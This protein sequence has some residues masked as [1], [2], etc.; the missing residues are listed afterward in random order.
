[1]QIFNSF[2]VPVRSLKFLPSDC[3]T[4]KEESSDELLSRK[5]EEALMPSAGRLMIPNF[6]KDV[7]GEE[8]DFGVLWIQV[9]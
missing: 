6:C 3:M 2:N 9:D 1:M 7:R 8:N 5:Y 4:G